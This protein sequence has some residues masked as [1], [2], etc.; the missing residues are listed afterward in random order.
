MADSKVAGN[1]AEEKK[2]FLAAATKL[3]QANVAIKASIEAARLNIT[4]MD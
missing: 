2:A 1:T 3:R 4:A